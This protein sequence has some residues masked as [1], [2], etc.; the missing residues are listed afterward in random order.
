MLPYPKPLSVRRELGS[1]WKDET[2]P[3]EFGVL[4]PSQPAPLAAIVL[5]DRQDGYAGPPAVEPVDTLDAIAA[6]TP[7]TSH[8]PEMEKPLQRMAALCDN[9]GGVMRV[10]YAE[11]EHLAPLVHGWLGAGS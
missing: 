7:E 11:A 10:T 2:D 6:L 4:P 5:L 3:L 1:L 9:V 8:L